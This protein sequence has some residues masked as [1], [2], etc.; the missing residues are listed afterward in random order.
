[1][2]IRTKEAVRYLGYGKNAV[3]DKTLQEIQDSFRELERLADKKS[4]YRIF[5]LSL[6]DENELKI[7]NVEIYSRNLRTNLKDCKQ[8]VLFA[9]TLGTEVDRLIRKM[10]VVDMAKAVV[11]QACAATLLEEYCDE[12]QQKIAEHMQEQGKY[13]RPR[14]SPGYGDFS[15]QH[16]KDV[17][18][19]LEAS[20]RTGVTMTDSY[21]LTPTKSVTA[22]IGIGD[23]E[24]NCNLNSCE[25]CDKTDCTYRRS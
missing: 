2:D 19:M 7:G 11:M 21:M 22:V 14:F 10:Q 6:K 17:L 13:I 8:V 20:K 15:I 16:Q 1:M 12:L 5:E 3:D 24:M 25:E 9:A 4:I 18:A 23:V